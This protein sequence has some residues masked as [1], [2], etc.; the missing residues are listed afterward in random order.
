MSA[1]CHLREEPSR[2]AADTRSPPAIQMR[3]WRGS[4]DRLYVAR[5]HDAR[6]IDPNE[7]VRVVA[8][9]VS[10]NSNAIAERLGIV[11]GLGR[12]AAERW[13]GEMRRKGCTEIHVHRT[14]AGAA[15]CRAIAADLSDG[16]RS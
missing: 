10:R 11:H 3:D 2:P 14:T 4:S 1:A 13:L 6:D 15:E 16:G 12:E 5:V 8:I 7:V 9:G